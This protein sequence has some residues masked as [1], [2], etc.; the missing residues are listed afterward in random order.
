MGSQCTMHGVTAWMPHSLDAL[1][2]GCMGC[3]LG[4]WAC[5]AAPRVRGCAFGAPAPLTR[6]RR[7]RPGRAGGWCTSTPQARPTHSTRGARVGVERELR[8][9]ASRGTLPWQ[10][11]PCQ[12]GARS[13]DARHSHGAWHGAWHGT[14]VVHGALHGASHGALHGALH[15]A[16]YVTWCVTWRVAPRVAPCQGRSRAAVRTRRAAA[17]AAPR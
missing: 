16:W 7:R 12:S 17:D 14:A 1:Q 11:R 4:A 10:A 8:V 3:S 13:H 15:G 9:H 5:S 2:P 6:T